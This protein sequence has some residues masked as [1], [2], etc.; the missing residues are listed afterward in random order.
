MAL[1]AALRADP[2]V[3]KVRFVP[4]EDALRELS[5]VPGMPEVL[6]SLGK[7]PLPDAFVV[8]AKEGSV[9]ALAAD[10]RKL[11]GVGLVQADAAWAKRL[12]A[13]PESRASRSGSSPGCWRAGLIAVTFNTIGLQVLTQRAE[14]EVLRLIGATDSFIR[15]PFY[16]LGSCRAPPGGL[17]RARDRRR[18]ARPAQPG[19]RPARRL[20]TAPSFRFVFLPAGDAFAVVGFAALIGW[21]GAYLS[22]SRRLSQM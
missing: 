12:G 14:I 11:P 20:R 3:A 8:S 18:R 22:V 13:L 16:Y 5:A 7:N 10:A 19:G 1:G 15:R 21:L 17:H 4:R 2:R 9:E 6:A